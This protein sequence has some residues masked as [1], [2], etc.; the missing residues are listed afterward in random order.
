MYIHFKIDLAITSARYIILATFIL[1]VWI[2]LRSFCSF[3]LDN[4]F[5]N[6][7]PI[8]FF[9]NPTSLQEDPDNLISAP[10]MPITR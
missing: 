3:I 10:I 8:R 2:T 6:F 5:V 7:L 9:H 1:E 4:V